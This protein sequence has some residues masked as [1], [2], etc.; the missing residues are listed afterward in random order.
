M[1]CIFKYNPASTLYLVV[2]DCGKIS[3]SLCVC[4]CVLRACMLTYKY[5]TS[6]KASI[7]SMYV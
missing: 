6:V 1:F 5:S 3:N 2:S 4:V 7:S